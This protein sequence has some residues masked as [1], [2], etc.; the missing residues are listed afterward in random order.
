MANRSQ[1]E[2]FVSYQES[3]LNSYVFGSQVTTHV[4]GGA[5]DS[6]VSMRCERPCDP[7]STGIRVT[8][9]FEHDRWMID[10][11]RR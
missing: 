1:V 5:I 8:G 6:A 11:A 10:Q 9:T 7:G 2:L 3:K 4:H